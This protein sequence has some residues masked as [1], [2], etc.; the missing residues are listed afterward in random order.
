MLIGHEALERLAGASVAVFGLGGVGSYTAEALARCGI[1]HLTLIDG[2]SV[3]PSNLNRQLVATIDTMGR[4]KAEAMAERIA[5]INPACRVNAINLF[6][7]DQS[8]GEINLSDFDYI[9]DCID[10]ISSKLLLIER[11]HAAKTPIISSMG[12][13]NKLDPTRF[14]VSDIY[15]TSVCPL[16]RV[17]RR[18]LRARNIESLKVVYSKEEPV[19]TASNPEAPSPSQKRP[20]GSIS[21]V[22]GSAGLIIASEIAKNLMA[23]LG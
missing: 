14:E 8:C 7:S 23:C 17:M 13:G 9:A 16:A 4:P 2:D 11:A 10:A 1:G 22:P 6:Y 18:E 12:A 21:F 15:Q 19:E 20:I 5:L 3:S